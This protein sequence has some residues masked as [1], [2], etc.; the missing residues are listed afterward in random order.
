MESVKE[1]W[2]KIAK[3]GQKKRIVYFPSGPETI[4]F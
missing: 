3:L 1:I 2:D 4:N